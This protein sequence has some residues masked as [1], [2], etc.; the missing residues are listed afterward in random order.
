MERTV[1][2]FFFTQCDARRFWCSWKSDSVAQNRLIKFFQVFKLCY[3]TSL[4]KTW[5]NAYL[6]VNYFKAFHQLADSIL[7]QCNEFWIITYW[8]AGSQLPQSC[9]FSFLENT[10][11]KIIH[12]SWKKHKKITITTVIL[13]VT[14]FHVNLNKI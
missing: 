8:Y 7:M 11:V 5:N 13:Y 3:I 12:N 4:N 1:V 14:K 10:L 9:P 6:F 2:L